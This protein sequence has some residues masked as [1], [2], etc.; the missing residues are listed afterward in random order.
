MPIELSY[1]DIT[2]FGNET[3][4]PPGKCINLMLLVQVIQKMMSRYP[5][6]VSVY[7]LQVLNF[8]DTCYWA[9]TLSVSVVKKLAVSSA[10]RV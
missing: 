10:Q 5:H 2:I 6:V 7:K 1:V 9:H 8:V 3:R 4:Q